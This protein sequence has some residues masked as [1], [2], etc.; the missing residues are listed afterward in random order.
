MSK[1]EKIHNRWDLQGAKPQSGF[2]K[3]FFLPFL[4]PGHAPRSFRK[5]KKEN[6]TLFSAQYGAFAHL[7]FQRY[8]SIL[9]E[10]PQITDN[11]EGFH[12]TLR[13]VA[14]ADNKTDHGQYTA[15][16]TQTHNIQ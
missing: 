12:F 6:T 7:Q 9:R 11:G 16:K 10:E 15:H 4:A 5:R 1:S 14:D 8:V 3:K 13:H 2:A